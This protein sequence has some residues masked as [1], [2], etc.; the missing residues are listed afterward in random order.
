MGVRYVGGGFLTNVPRFD[1]TDAQVGALDPGARAAIARSAFYEPAPDSAVNGERTHWLVPRAGWPRVLMVTPTLR[2]EPEMAAAARRIVM[3]YPGVIDWL[4]TR[5]NPRPEA[6]R[7]GY[8]NILLNMRKARLQALGGGYDALFV[9]ESDVVAPAGALLMLVEVDA[10]VAG[11]LYPLRGESQS[12]NAF[13]YVPKVTS[14]NAPLE[15]REIERLWDRQTR[16][17]GVC[18]GCTL[19]WRRVLE[20][21]DFRL[22][23]GEVPAPDWWLMTDCNE[24]GFVQVLDL[25][26]RCAHVQ[27]DGT[28]LL[29]KRSGEVERLAPSGP[30]Q[31]SMRWHI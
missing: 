15:R 25:R 20:Q 10:D 3:G 5:D 23:D 27:S 21:I 11:G 28:C 2:W 29:T 16:T 8:D 1:M 24:A 13:S 26:V 4:V 19:I 17:N 22:V 9:M 12:H 18:L 30:A 14:P 31:E 7:R 6:E